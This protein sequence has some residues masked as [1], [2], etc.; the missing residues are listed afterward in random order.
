[1]LDKITYSINLLSLMSLS[2]KLFIYIKSTTT[3]SYKKLSH[4]NNLIVNVILSKL[5]IPVSEV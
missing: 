4:S 2:K 1:M 5:F 3:I